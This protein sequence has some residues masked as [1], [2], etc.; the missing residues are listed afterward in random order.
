[1]ILRF[2]SEPKKRVS[3]ESC[4]SR[5]SRSIGLDLS[6]LIVGSLYLHANP[7]LTLTTLVYGL[8]RI[9]ESDHRSHVSINSL[10]PSSHHFPPHLFLNH[11][12]HPKLQL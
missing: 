3:M 6:G 8:I 4:Q 9:K 12:Q 10:L 5:R 1:M 2:S 11:F 7:F